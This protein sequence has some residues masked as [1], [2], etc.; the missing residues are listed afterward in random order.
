[1]E[2]APRYFRRLPKAPLEVRAVE[3]FRQATAAVAFY[4]RPTPDGSRPGIYYV[5]WPT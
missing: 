4:N 2:V 5:N 3:P 1:M